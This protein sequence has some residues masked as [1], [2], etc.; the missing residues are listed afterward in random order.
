MI[1]FF[2][3]ALFVN[4]GDQAR[5]GSWRSKCHRGP[6][7]YFRSMNF[8]IAVVARFERGTFA[9]AR[10]GATDVEST[11]RKLGARLADGL[12][13]DDADRFAEL[14]HAARK[15]GCGRSTARKLRDGIRK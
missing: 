11:H 4:D 5:N 3:A 14:D 7:R 15:Q 6:R 13:G 9:D 8:T 12:R 2:F 10:R 1:A